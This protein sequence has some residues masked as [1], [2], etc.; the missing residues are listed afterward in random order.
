MKIKRKKKPIVMSIGAQ[1]RIL[2][3]S[4]SQQHIRLFILEKV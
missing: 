2:P 3:K 4:F 1:V